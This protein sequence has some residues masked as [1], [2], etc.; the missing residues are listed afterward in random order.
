ML[1]FLNLRQGN[2]DGK[3]EIIVRVP[4]L[5]QT[6]H[7]LGGQTTSHHCLALTKRELK[8]ECYLVLAIKSGYKMQIITVL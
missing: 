1:P 2:G 8:M 3:Q 7:R 6:N 5:V 4:I